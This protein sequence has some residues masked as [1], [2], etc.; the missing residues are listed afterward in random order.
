MQEPRQALKVCIHAFKSWLQYSA[1]CDPW[2]PAISPCSSLLPWIGQKLPLGCS[3]RT[4]W[5]MWYSSVSH[6]FFAVWQQG[7]PRQDILRGLQGS[8][9]V[10]VP[11]PTPHMAIG[12]E[13][14][15]PASLSLSCYFPGWQH[16]WENPCVR[17]AFFKMHRVQP[18]PPCVN[19]LQLARWFASI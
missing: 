9:G 4:I 19:F 10:E 6:L 18:G 14:A 15:D 13:A 12:D 3:W 8:R 7:L 16:Q 2:V 17:W 11:P 1:T 5:S